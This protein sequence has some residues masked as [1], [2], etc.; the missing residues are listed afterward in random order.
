[1]K[2]LRVQI[3]L[4]LLTGMGITGAQ[5]E[6]PDV[7]TS[8]WKC[9]QCPF[10][11]GFGA[12]AELGL[13]YA[14][15]A[16]AAYGRY[17]G[18]DHSG[19]YVDAGGDG[20]WTSADG[21]E[22]SYDFDRLGLASRS[23][24]VE[25]G[26]QGHYDLRLG[27][28]G[29][30]DRLYDTAQTP[31]V[32]AGGSRLRLPAGWQP[33]G[34]TGGMTQ[35]TSSLQ[36][37]RIGSDRHT[38][39]VSGNY[40]PGGGWRLYGEFSH[41]EKDGTGLTGASFLTD[42]LQLPL[43]IHYVTDSVEVGVAW[44]GAVADAR[45]S[46]TG[47]WFKDNDQSLSFANPY[48]P[49][50]PSAALGQLSLAPG[51][52]LQQVALTG[53]IRLPIW[54]ATTLNFAASVGELKQDAAFLAPSALGSASLSPNNLSGDV[55]LS[56]YSLAMASRPLARLYLRGNARYD[57]RDDRT[58]SFAITDVVTDSL[59]GSTTVTPR[60][61]E[62][63][64]HLDGSADY[65][66]SALVRVGVGGDLEHI[67]YSPGQ[68]LTHSQESRSWVHATL[69]PTAALTLSVKAGDARRATSS[70]DLSAL[71]PTENPLLSVFNYAARDR[72]FLTFTADW[73]INA[74][75]D[76][77][78]EGSFAND[79]YRRTELGLQDGRDREVATTL[80][81]TASNVLT[82]RMNGGYQRLAADQHGENLPAAA[83]W[84]AADGQHFWTAGLGGDWTIHAHWNL[85]AAY[86]RSTSAVDASTLAGGVNQ[87][88]PQNRTALE[89]LQ[90][91][92]VYNWTP[93]CRVRFHY[94]HA[95]YGSNDWALDNVEPGTVP[96]LLSLGIPAY[97]YDVNA[98]GLSFLYRIGR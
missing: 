93:A 18:I 44:K 43:P 39:T 65:R 42:A 59:P 57:G 26:D 24:S 16:N 11:K 22:I 96:N 64:V 9:S 76:W 17:T 13:Q 82:F 67:T 50:T 27:Y 51:N 58:P 77:S 66:F 40:L 60:F 72:E 45:V 32:G 31:F 75:L 86:L 33:A 62:D 2:S 88:F 73:E 6:A 15:A 30:P 87:A 63:R 46:Y 94:E 83:A 89:T 98:F 49:I 91:G 37:T 52:Q 36:P 12:D 55:H 97:R 20:R 47:S 74:Q 84:N 41:Q 21:P 28:A 90:I 38:T 92:A 69:N 25:A 4:V 35:L 70:F 85:T 54:T 10:P 56:H 53:Q 71:P 81:W 48:L 78:T 29:Q 23:G 8:A 19:T 79:A 5:A 14:D 80:I 1:M 3:R 95:R 34:D 7:D 68:V 61:G